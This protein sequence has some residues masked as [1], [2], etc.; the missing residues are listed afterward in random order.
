MQLIRAE[1]EPGSER[2]RVLF[3]GNG[4]NQTPA[5]RRVLTKARIGWWDVSE[6]LPSIDAAACHKMVSAPSV[7]GAVAIVDQGAPEVRSGED[8]D[9][10]P[11]IALDHGISESI[12]CRGNLYLPLG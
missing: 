5:K 1:T 8:R 3:N 10:L 7:I 9:I 2:C 12:D 11:E 6:E 4:G